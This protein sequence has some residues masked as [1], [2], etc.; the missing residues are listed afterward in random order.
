MEANQ[1]MMS[2]FRKFQDMQAKAPSSEGAST[3]SRRNNSSWKKN[4]QKG[5]KKNGI[6][7]S[8]VGQPTVNP[9]P[10][11]VVPQGQYLSKTSTELMN[12]PL[13]EKAYFPGPS[14]AFMAS[15]TRE[16]KLS[17]L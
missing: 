8:T 9:N 16:K 10:P 12:D 1:E 14:S 2:M 11:G 6:P 17:G 4:P 3:S 15:A 13:A 5:G 7:K